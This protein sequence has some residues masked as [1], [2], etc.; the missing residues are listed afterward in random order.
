MLSKTLVTLAILPYLTCARRLGQNP[1]EPEL[2]KN[3]DPRA[4]ELINGC[5]KVKTAKKFDVSQYISAPWYAHQQ[6]ENPYAPL[7]RNHCVNTK[8]SLLDTPSFWGATLTV[9]ASAKEDA[10]GQSF[11]NELCAYQNEWR[12]SKL[13]MAPCFLPK[14]VGMAFWVV[15]YN[16]EEGYALVSA[17]QP[18]VQGDDGCRTG[19]VGDSGLWIFSRSPERDNDLIEKVRSVAQEAGFDVSVLNDVS[20]EGCY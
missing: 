18:T 2:F 3:D 15:A 1:V 5:K 13:T 8:G 12:A 11:E 17:G 14:S 10:S 4:L 20:Q 9:D 7:N 16:E 19:D 6:A